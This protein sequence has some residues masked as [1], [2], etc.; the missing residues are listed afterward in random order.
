MNAFPN[1]FRLALVKNSIPI[2]R[3]SKNPSKGNHILKFNT[4][5]I[6][7]ACAF[8]YGPFAE[9]ILL[10]LRFKNEHLTARFVD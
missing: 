1:I 3:N 7:L 10:A 6:D 8:G 9:N 2:F 4:L 5:P